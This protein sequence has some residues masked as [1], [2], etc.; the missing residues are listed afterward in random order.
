MKGTIFVRLNGDIEIDNVL[1]EIDLYKENTG[2]K[3][4]YIK[5]DELQKKIY[6]KYKNVIKSPAYIYPLYNLVLIRDNKMKL[7]YNDI[8]YMSTFTC[9]VSNK[10]W[11]HKWRRIRKV[12]LFRV[13]SSQKIKGW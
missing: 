5:T 1:I 6:E 8:T 12:I 13:A 10:I 7:Y 2:D 4:I 9:I 11:S 3:L